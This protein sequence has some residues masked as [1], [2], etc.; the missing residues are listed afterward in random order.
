[1]DAARQA[2]GTEAALESKS[3]KGGAMPHDLVDVD[4]NLL[5]PDLAPSLQSLI[6]TA[7]DVG[8]RQFVVPGSTLV[9]SAAALDLGSR[10]PGVCFG[11]AGMHPYHCHAA[12]TASDVS[13]LDVLVRR[14]ECVA[15][16]ETGLDNSEGFP[17]T[18]HQMPW[19]V[20]QLDL[21]C[22]VQKPLFLHERLA[23]ETV[24]VELEAR[25]DVL[26]PV[27]VHC[28]TGTPD[29]LRW[30][31]DFGC[32]VGFTGFLLNTKRA[33]AVRECLQSGDIVIP[34]DR[35]VIET[36]V[37]LIYTITSPQFRL[38]HALSQP[39]ES[40]QSS[41]MLVFLVGAPTTQPASH[42]MHS[43]LRVAD[44][45]VFLFAPLCVSPRDAPYM[46]F[47]RC[48][49]NEPHDRRKTSPNVPSALPMVLAEVA[50]LLSIPEDEL[51]RCTSANARR[52]F[53]FDL[54][55]THDDDT[56]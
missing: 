53:G 15:V 39:V 11:T 44:A 20:A 32:Y 55:P 6:A 2:V 24:S 27:L 46:G 1:M 56:V 4:A 12:P 21:A 9:D 38:R 37:R 23:F 29:E 17:R 47:K 13:K 30:Y 36:C 34:R 22:A 8:V 50:A 40:H 48:R 7:R 19:F 3:S 35:V 25:R 54:P 18:E 45:H 28:F 5:H 43:F 41:S 42:C 26:P 16:G 14:P 33:V 31:L 49:A 52:L 51:A 10:Q